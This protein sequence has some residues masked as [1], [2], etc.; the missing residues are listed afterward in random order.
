MPQRPAEELTGG[1]GRW[2]GRPQDPSGP[3]VCPALGAGE[4]ESYGA[5]PG[6]GSRTYM[7]GLAYPKVQD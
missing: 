3:D 7:T 6:S 1:T 5:A 4:A 2:H